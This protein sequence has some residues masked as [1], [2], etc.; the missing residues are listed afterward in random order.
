MINYINKPTGFRFLVA[1]MCAAALPVIIGLILLSVPIIAESEPSC[2]YRGM[3]AKNVFITCQFYQELGYSFYWVI[4]LPIILSFIFIA[5][6]IAAMS[7]S[8][9]RKNEA[10]IWGDIFLVSITKSTKAN[11]WVVI[12]YN[13]IVFLMLIAAAFSTSGAGNIL[14]VI[15][16]ALFYLALIQF[17]LWLVITLPLAIICAAIFGL[18][19][20]PNK[21]NTSYSNFANPVLEEHDT[22]R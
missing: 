12:I 14:A 1:G 17:G 21:T 4:M 18:I 8:E 19:I 15:V 11:F 7:I 5:P 6:L 13:S 10:I 22:D 2:T 16:A 3:R 20:R 9:L